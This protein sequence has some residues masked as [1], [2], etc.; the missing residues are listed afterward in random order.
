MVKLVNKFVL[1]FLI[2]NSLK[3][4][5]LMDLNYVRRFSAYV[6]TFYHSEYITGCWS[7]F[8]NKISYDQ[9]IISW[10]LGYMWSVWELTLINL[11]VIFKIN[12]KIYVKKVSTFT[13]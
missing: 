9:L 3:E 4:G 13:S 5:F 1:K 2:F 12:G 8:R 6:S 11:S 10:I 7:F